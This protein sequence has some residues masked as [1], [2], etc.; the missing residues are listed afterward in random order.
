MLRI[1]FGAEIFRLRILNV[2]KWNVILAPK[3]LGHFVVELHLL[4]GVIRAPHRSLESR[5]F[6]GLKPR[7]F[8]SRGANKANAM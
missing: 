3:Q 7:I 2:Y 8:D 5:N 4:L 6:V 1:T